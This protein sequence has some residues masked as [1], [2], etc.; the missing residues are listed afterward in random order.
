M[1]ILRLILSAVLGIAVTAGQAAA[2]N[3]PHWRGPTMNGIS[4]EK[5]LPVEWSDTKNVAW[6]VA[7]PGSAGASP[8]VWKDRVFVTSMDG[9]S[10]LLICIST[11]GKTLWQK[12]V[13]KGNKN[14]RRDEGN[15]AA[16]T[17]G[18]EAP[19]AGGAD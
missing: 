7:L 8:V 15:S 19:S 18:G 13:G 9:Q 4:T 6:K 1:P 17:S 3:W 14:A 12:V 2:E 11:A 16:H 10:Q 5:N